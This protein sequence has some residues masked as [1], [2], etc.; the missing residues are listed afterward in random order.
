MS[1]GDWTYVA[2]AINPVGGLLVAVPWG[3]FERQYA[4]PVLLLSGPPLGYVQVLVVD[5]LGGRLE[6]LE[7]WR[8]LFLRRRSPKVDRLLRSGGAFWP[9]FLL[10]PL[11]GPWLVMAAMRYAGVPQRQIALPVL[12][13]LAALTALLVGACLAVP[14]WFGR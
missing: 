2:F 12:S 4:W 8:R 13:S 11:V 14:A 6:R 5:L 9:V 10:T 1:P 7:L 3:V